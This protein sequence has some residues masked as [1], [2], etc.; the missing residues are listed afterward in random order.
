AAEQVGATGRERLRA[1]ARA[2]SQSP[3]D[4]MPMTS[5]SSI[6]PAGSSPKSG[7]S[8]GAPLERSTIGCGSRSPPST[9]TP[10]AAWRSPAKTSGAGKSPR[11]HRNKPNEAR[12]D[13]V[14]TIEPQRHMTKTGKTIIIRMAAPSDAAAINAI[15]REA[16]A[17]GTYHIT[18]VDEF[19]VTPEDEAAWICRHAELP[20]DI[21]LVA[22]AEDVVIGLI[23]L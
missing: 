23:H 2:T 12:E 19:S 3:T 5:S 8:L 9:C 13:C 21:M 7:I 18:E 6:G 10:A 16:F 1:L 14:G 11:T 22:E 4:C 20:A 17:E 15:T